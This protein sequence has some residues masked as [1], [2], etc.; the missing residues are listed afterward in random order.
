[1]SG[2]FFIRASNIIR[3]DGIGSIVDIDGISLLICDSEDWYE[4]WD[5]DNNVYD[6][7]ENRLKTALSSKGFLSVPNNL[8]ESISKVS[9]KLFPR[10]YYSSDDGNLKRIDKW[11]D[12]AKEKGKKIN[13]QFLMILVKTH[14]I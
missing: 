14:H 13:Q 10:W 8:K 3:R 2:N 4:Q 5:L 12:K 1:M 6:I 7:E 9:A 11:K